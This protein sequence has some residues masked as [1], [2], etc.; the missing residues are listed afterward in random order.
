MMQLKVVCHIEFGSQRTVNKLMQ[1]S[2]CRETGE[3]RWEPVPIEQGLAV[4]VPR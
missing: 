4:E 3:L 2:R 1:A